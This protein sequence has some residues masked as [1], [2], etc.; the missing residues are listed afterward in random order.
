MYFRKISPST[1]CLYSAA[2]MLLRSLSAASQSLASKPRLAPLPLVDLVAFFLPMSAFDL[3]DWRL[4]AIYHPTNGL[5]ACGRDCR[6]GGGQG[7]SI[8]LSAA[9]RYPSRHDCQHPHSVHAR[10]EPFRQ[11]RWKRLSEPWQAA[12]Q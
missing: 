6:L 12:N 4:A 8:G 3:R 11:L 7:W 5:S 9:I 1:T 10:R 2:S